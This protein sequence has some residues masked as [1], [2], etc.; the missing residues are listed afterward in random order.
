MQWLIRVRTIEF[1]GEL[2]VTHFEK[3]RLAVS[4]AIEE[5]PIADVESVLATSL[6]CCEC[7]A[8]LCFREG[9]FQLLEHLGTFVERGVKGELCGCS[10]NVVGNC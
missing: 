5:N 10:W 3:I 1:S 2:V 6:V 8:L 9:S 4:L 7:H